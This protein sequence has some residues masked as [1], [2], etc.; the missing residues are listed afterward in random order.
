[1]E[2]DHHRDHPLARPA[3]NRRRDVVAQ[4][5]HEHNQP[6]SEHAGHRQRC[7]DA[8]EDPH[9]SGTEPLGR[10]QQIAID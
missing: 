2:L 7:D 9:R 3:E 6:A 5:T 1:M 4:R 8:A 10:H